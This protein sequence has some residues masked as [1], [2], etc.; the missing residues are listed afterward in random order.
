MKDNID[1][2]KPIHREHIP[3]ESY[4]PEEQRRIS[5]IISRID[6]TKLVWEGME[7]RNETGKNLK[8]RLDLTRGTGRLFLYIADEEKI[9]MKDQEVEYL[10]GWR[11]VPKSYYEHTPITEFDF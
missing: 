4:P 3:I 8:V 2:S 5:E 10:E 7:V 11:V 1:V 6:L 9:S